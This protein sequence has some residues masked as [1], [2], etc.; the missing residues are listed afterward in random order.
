MKSV[1]SKTT[2]KEKLQCTVVQ[3]VRSDETKLKPMIIFKE[4]FQGRFPEGYCCYC[5]NESVNK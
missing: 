1:L 4:S 3:S 2:G 5:I